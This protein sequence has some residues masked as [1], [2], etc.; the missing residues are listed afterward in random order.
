LTE[1]T[2]MSVLPYGDI[3]I[4]DLSQL[5][6]GPL[7]TQVL[8]DFGADVIKVERPYVGE[9]GRRMHPVEPSGYSSF[10]AANNRNK[11][12]VS[13]DLKAPGGRAVFTGLVKTAD[14]VA[15]NFRPGVLERLGFGYDRLKELNPRII[16]ALASGYGQ[17]GPYRERRGQDLAAQALGGVMALTGDADGPPRPVGTYAADYL[18][19]MHFAQAIMAAL[20][21][22]AR[23]GDGQV[24]DVS[25]LNAAVAVHL[26]EGSAYLNNQ[27]PIPR[28]RPHLAHSRNTALYGA[29][30]T[31]DGK[32]IAIIGDLFIDQPWQRV[33]R[34]LD[35]G[36]GIAQDPRFAELPALAKHSDAAAEILQAAFGRLTRQEAEERLGKEDVL[37]AP[38]QEYAEVFADPQVLHNGMVVDVELEGL[39]ARRLVG[40]P[41]RLLGTPAEPTRLPPPRVGQHNE[42]ILAD[43]GYSA[44]DIQALKDSGAVGD[45]NDRRAR[46]EGDCW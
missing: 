23:T 12:S 4:L 5:E 21:A 36:D 28:P 39:G 9:I 41:V 16:L 42:E 1:G 43:L 14:V 32:A 13:V 15:S 26:Q 17:S 18:A 20:A 6:Q 30:Q 46:G 44:K 37:W 7:G 3:R 27:V 35:I 8:A 29:Y 24:L 19:A 22:R 33:C 45:E 10:W 25:L 34:A 11:R 38:V 40:Q 31:L 2:G